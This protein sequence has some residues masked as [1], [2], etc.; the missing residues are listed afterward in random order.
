VIADKSTTLGY[1]YL[2]SQQIPNTGPNDGLVF[3]GNWSDLL[4]GSWDTTDLIV[5]PYSRAQNAQIRAI[6][7]QVWDTNLRYPKAFA[8]SLDPGYPPDMF[9]PPPGGPLKA[10]PEKNK[11]SRQVSGK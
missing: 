2:K 10:A 5:D 7:N 6:V 11:E 4:I 9:P 1:R 3:F 8:V